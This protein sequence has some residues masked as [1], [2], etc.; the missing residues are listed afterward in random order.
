MPTTALIVE[1]LVIGAMTLIWLI[2]LFAAFLPSPN[3]AQMAQL[4]SLIREAS[5]LLALPALALTYAVGWITNFCSERLFF[6][7]HRIRDLRFGGATRYETA[8]LL[9]LQRGSDNLVQEVLADRHVIRLARGGVMNFTLLAITL[10]IHGLRGRTLAW[11]LALLCLVLAALSF[12][13][14]RKKYC[15]HYESL[16]RIDEFL[17][18][19]PAKSKDIP[20]TGAP[21]FVS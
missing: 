4:A 1:V 13:Q 20:R 11:P 18:K 12:A 17:S 10:S 6:F 16:E 5:P 2:V 9:M 19:E 7:R 21:P 3:S 8:K 15:S 14:W